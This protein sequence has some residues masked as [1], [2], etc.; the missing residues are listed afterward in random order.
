M[1]PPSPQHSKLLKWQTS[2]VVCFIPGKEQLYGYL[3]TLD[4]TWQWRW[5]GIPVIQTYCKESPSSRR[6]ASWGVRKKLSI[7]TSLGKSYK[8]KHWITK[9]GPCSLWFYDTFCISHTSFVHL[10][11]WKEISSK[12]SYHLVAL[13]PFPCRPFSETVKR[14]FFECWSV[15]PVLTSTELDNKT[16]HRA[17]STNKI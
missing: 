11:L 5:A 8:A 6:L 14:N 7:N 9:F 3:G 13:Y 12:H 1:F 17:S 15:R 4:R 10:K 2:S 16:E